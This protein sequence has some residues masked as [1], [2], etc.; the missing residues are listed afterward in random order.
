M[1]SGPAYL[2]PPQFGTVTPL[3]GSAPANQIN[4]I[5]V[6]A[7]DPNGWGVNNSL[8]ILIGGS[9]YNGKYNYCQIAFVPADIQ[10]PYLLSDDYTTWTGIWQDGRAN[11]LNSQ[12]QLIGSG[13][14]YSYS[15]PGNTTLTL[16][17]SIQF[18]PAFVGVNSIMEFVLDQWGNTGNWGTLRTFTVVGQP[19]ITSQCGDLPLG[20][21]GT[22]YSTQLQVPGKSFNNRPALARRKL[23]GRERRDA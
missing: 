2:G 4:T 3:N 8:D 23:Q 17:F 21:L 6:T 16:N 19:I 13:F 5:T 12:C 20:V 11:A 14:S 22:P 7:I 15:G 1:V 9:Y 10:S 18:F